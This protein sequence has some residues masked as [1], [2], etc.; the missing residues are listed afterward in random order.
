MRL[1]PKPALCTIRTTRLCMRR[2]LWGRPLC[3]HCRGGPPLLQGLPSIHV[4]CQKF[5][6][7]LLQ[8][9][10]QGTTHAPHPKCVQ[11]TF[12]RQYLRVLR[13]LIKKSKQLFGVILWSPS[14]SSTYIAAYWAHLRN[15][16][17][18]RQAGKGPPLRLCQ[19]LCKR[20]VVASTADGLSEIAWRL[21][22]RVGAASQLQPASR[23]LLLVCSLC[24]LGRS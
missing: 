13:V 12:A 15:G 16:G 8:I 20:S 6:K 21:A 3:S 14:L 7:R 22:D 17:E 1:R 18:R 11:I 19:L 4:C 10:E 2:H 23:V 9:V 24:V 5:R